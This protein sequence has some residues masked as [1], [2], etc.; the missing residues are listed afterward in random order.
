M[1][2][3]AIVLTAVFAVP[4]A[5]EKLS[6]GAISKYFNDM[7]TA[8][9]VF[10]QI[11]ADGSLSSGTILIKR[12]GQ[13]RFEYDA[14]DS[15]LV[16]ATNRAI[17]IIDKKSNDKPETYPLKRTPLWLI[18]ERNV[19]LSRA[20]MVRGHAFDGT[21]TIITAADPDQP[22]IGTIQMQ[23]L[24]DPVRLNQWTITDESGNTTTVK[25][26]NLTYGERILNRNFDV[27]KYQ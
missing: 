16:L 6:L 21:A 26:G 1:R 13:M 24:H 19:D 18:L 23:F 20:R 7:K 9:G 14:P 17:Y 15:A 22:E 12:P 8:Q 4:A 10:E 3:I 2:L 5:A 25:L 11:N 27:S